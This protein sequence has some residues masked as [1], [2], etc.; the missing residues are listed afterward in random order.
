MEDDVRQEILKDLKQ[1]WE[2]ITQGNCVFV[3]ATE[4]RNIDEL[5]NTI[6]TKLEKCIRSATRTKRNI[7]LGVSMKNNSLKW[8]KIADSVNAIDWQ[9]NQMAVIE[10]HGK[11]DYSNKNW[12]GCS[13]CAH[14]CP[15]AGGV[16]ADGFIDAKGLYCLPLAPLPFNVTNGSNVSGEGYYLKTYSIEKRAA[17]LFIGIGGEW[18]DRYF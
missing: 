3:S 12:R 6:L 5:R 9:A 17:G 18:P 13:A 10:V 7:L 8:H 1:K 11:T 14:K 4:R 15:H 2:N 16:L